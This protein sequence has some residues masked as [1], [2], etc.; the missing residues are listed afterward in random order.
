[1]TKE[2]AK[3]AAKDYAKFWV[4]TQLLPKL[5]TAANTATDNPWLA[6]LYKAGFQLAWHASDTLVDLLAE[7]T[8]MALQHLMGQDWPALLKSPKYE[9]EDRRG[10]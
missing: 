3:Q 9:R 4:R 6:A 1:M 8:D 10:E 2:D 5:E 7:Y